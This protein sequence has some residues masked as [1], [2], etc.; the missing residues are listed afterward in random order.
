MASACA[1]APARI[2]SHDTDAIAQTIDKQLIVD[3]I[4]AGQVEPLCLLAGQKLKFDRAARLPQSRSR[5]VHALRPM[6]VIPGDVAGLEVLPFSQGRQ[7]LRVKEDRP[8]ESV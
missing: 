8:A 4:L 2:G 1:A 5:T 7:V 6:K 3:E